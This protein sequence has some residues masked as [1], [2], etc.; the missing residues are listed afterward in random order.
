MEL[1]QERWH[2][3]KGLALRVESWLAECDGKTWQ[4][5]KDLLLS[6]ADEMKA[7]LQELVEQV[8]WIEG[9]DQD[10]RHEEAVGRVLRKPVPKERVFVHW[11][12]QAPVAGGRK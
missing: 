3:L 9:E 10:A 11:M 4:D 5:E 8:D 2:A 6:D 1:S 12:N 7:L